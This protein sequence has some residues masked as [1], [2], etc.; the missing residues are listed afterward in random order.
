MK[1][2]NKTLPDMLNLLNLARN[3]TIKHFRTMLNLL[4]LLNIFI[5]KIDVKLILSNITHNYIL[6]VISYMGLF[7]GSLYNIYVTN[8]NKELN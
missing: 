8:S 5:E 6:I 3:N 7:K 2:Y 1:Q 4:N